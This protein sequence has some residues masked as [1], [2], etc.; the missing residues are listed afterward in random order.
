MKRLLVIILSALLMISLLMGTSSEAH[1]DEYNP[2][3][4][5]EWELEYI[6]DN[7]G[8]RVD[9]NSGGTIEIR[10]DSKE[11]DSNLLKLSFH[12]SKEDDEYYVDI[13][14]TVFG[15]KNNCRYDI[16]GT[17][18]PS[19]ENIMEYVGDDFNTFDYDNGYLKTNRNNYQYWYLKKVGG[20]GESG[21][22]SSLGDAHNHEWVEGEI[23]AASCEHD[24]LEGTY[25]KI[26][27]AIKEAQIISAYEYALNKYA[28]PKINAA[29]PGQTV[30]FEFKEWNSFPKSFMEKLVEKSASGVT[31]VFKY[32]WNHK[33]QTITIP[34]G[35]QINLDFD[36]YG[37]A[38]MAELY[39]MY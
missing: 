3:L 35:T 2:Y 39:G 17:N 1:A 16:S 15:N 13:S 23:Y 6:I 4:G 14:S 10:G 7:S 8:N 30:T 5:T 27:G 9:A 31:F 33:L 26:C 32:K 19:V 21:E 29:K 22:G 36:Y 11:F 24:G 12:S 25:C 38:K 20:S 18:P 28:V 37:P 34:A